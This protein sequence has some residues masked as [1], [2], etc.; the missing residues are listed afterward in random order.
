[1]DLEQAS[2]GSQGQADGHTIA[3]YLRRRGPTSSEAP[4]AQ[5]EAEEALGRPLQLMLSWGGWF[6]Q[7]K[8]SLPSAISHLIPFPAF[9][10]LIFQ[11][12]FREREIFC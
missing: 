7:K 8:L 3:G 6:Q 1:M 12:T 4:R 11:P 5:G 9:K 2:V 10:H